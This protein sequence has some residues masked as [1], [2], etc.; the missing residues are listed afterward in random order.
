[1]LDAK[2]QYVIAQGMAG[3]WLLL[4]LMLTLTWAL[5]ELPVVCLQ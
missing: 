2:G 5:P 3:V 4:Q 1:M